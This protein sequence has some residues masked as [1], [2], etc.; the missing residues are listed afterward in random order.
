MQTFLPF[1]DFRASASVLDYRRL[2][3]QRVE[4]LQILKA[5][6]DPLYGWQNHPAVRMWRGYTRSLV[7]YGAA[8]CRE[9]RLRGYQDNTLPKILAFDCDG[10]PP[11]WLGNEALHSAYRAC[12]LLKD[13]EHYGQFEWSE[14]PARFEAWPAGGYRES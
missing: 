10:S 6:N 11:R 3:K 9:W 8:I 14:R 2:G 1:P 7:E 13:P 12:L 4:C 5:L